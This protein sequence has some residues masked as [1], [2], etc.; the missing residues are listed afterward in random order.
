[1]P[2]VVDE[3]VPGVVV[4]EKHVYMKGERHRDHAGDM[5]C[6][7]Y[8]CNSH[9]IITFP[10]VPEMP[11][12][13]DERVT[14]SLL[15]REISRAKNASILGKIEQRHRDHA[16]DMPC[17]SYACVSY[18]NCLCESDREMPE[19]VFE[20]VT[21]SLLLGKNT[22]I[23]GRIGQRHRDPAGDPLC[24]AIACISHTNCPIREC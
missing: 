18:I 7:S 11:V 23:L 12:V 1:M 17:H 9:T 15:G 8:A 16:G 13:V 21:L 10:R 22:S 3:R 4:W 6:H 20:R 19:V 5:P 24:H 14:L 2:V